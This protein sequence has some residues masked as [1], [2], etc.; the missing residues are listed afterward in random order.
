MIFCNNIVPPFSSNKQHHTVIILV[1]GLKKQPCL[2]KKEECGKS[3]Y[4]IKI[5]LKKLKAGQPFIHDYNSKI[6]KLYS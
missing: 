5:I 3:D 2:F 1:A 4:F 6:Y